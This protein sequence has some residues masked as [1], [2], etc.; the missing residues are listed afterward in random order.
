[1]TVPPYK[2]ILVPTDG[3]EYSFYAAEHAVYLAKVLGAKLYA[4]S[5]VNAPL[6][7]HAG[8]HYAESKVDMEK[9]AQEAVLKIKALCDENG[10]E[11]KEM[12]VEGEPKTAIVDVACKIEADLI[13][14]GSIG[15]SALERVLIGSV[16]DSVLRHALC[17]VLMVR[18]T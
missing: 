9:A 5:V 1:M 18:R 2:N 3:S 4:I 8:I 15:M 14:I 16:S 7:F 13:V 11:C 10:V 17:P 6:A 12:V